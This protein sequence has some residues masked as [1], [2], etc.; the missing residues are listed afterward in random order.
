MQQ[1]DIQNAAGQAVATSKTFL[2]RQL[3]DRSTQL[4]RQVSSTAG[5]LRTIGDQLRQS[6]TSAAAAGLADRG[7]EF[8]ERIGTY[9][10]DSDSDRLIADLEDFARERPWAVASAALVLGFAASRVLKSSS[11]KRYR[12][13]DS[14]FSTGSNRSNR[15]RSSSTPASGAVTSTY[16]AYGSAA[17]RGTEVDDLTPETGSHATSY[18]SDAV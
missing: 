1:S 12:A 2:S 6:E 3:D 11:S 17:P 7:A 8:V 5:D 18:A 4:G 15:N 9:L 13:Y 14:E 10:Q 16:T